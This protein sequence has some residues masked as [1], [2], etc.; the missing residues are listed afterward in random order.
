ML[1]VLGPSGSGKST[2]ARALAGLVPHTL[3]GSWQ[4][5]LRIGELE[6]ATTPARFL[7]ERVGLVF[8]DPD[9]QLV[10]SRVD[11]EVAFGL[12]NRGWPRFEMAARVPEALA[13]AARP[14]GGVVYRTAASEAPPETYQRLPTFDEVRLNPQAQMAA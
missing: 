4:G 13:Q 11:D 9:S 3:A 7:G 8:Q 1:L 10:M 14:V 6:V 2:L 5:S 12:E